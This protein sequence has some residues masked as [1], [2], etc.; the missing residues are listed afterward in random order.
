MVILLRALILF[1]AVWLKAEIF[2]SLVT[3]RN[4]HWPWLFSKA[5]NPPTL[6]PNTAPRTTAVHS[7]IIPISV[8]DV[9]ASATTHT[10]VET[11]WH[12]TPIVAAERRNASLKIDEKECDFTRL[13]ESAAEL[14]PP[15]N[16]SEGIHLEQWESVVHQLYELDRLSRRNR[17]IIM[18]RYRERGYW[19]LR[20]ELDDLILKPMRFA[21]STLHRLQDRL[22]VINVDGV[23]S[24]GWDDR[25]RLS[26]D[27][28]DAVRADINRYLKNNQ[29]TRVM[30][31]WARYAEELRS[32]NCP[33]RNCMQVGEE[34]IDNFAY[35]IIH[36]LLRSVRR[37]RSEL[38]P[39]WIDSLELNDY[40]AW[41]YERVISELK[42]MATRLG[43]EWYMKRILNYF[44]LILGVI[45]SPIRVVIGFFFDILNNLTGLSFGKVKSAI[46]Q[47][48]FTYEN[49]TQGY[50]QLDPDVKWKLL[51]SITVICFLLTLVNLLIHGVFSHELI[52][53]GTALR[54]R[55]PEDEGEP[56]AVN[57]PPRRRS[58]GEANQQ[59]EVPEFE[60]DG[61]RTRYNRIRRQIRA[62]IF[63]RG[64]RNRR[65]ADTRAVEQDRI[66]AMLDNLRLG[67]PDIS[68]KGA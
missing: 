45:F 42:F 55:P 43:F 48:G 47:H 6:G 26:L 33:K 11:V 10:T 23:K 49:V 68:K 9:T 28:L 35:E 67:I 24:T 62:G 50:Q 38:N 60:S 36:D 61:E 2:N 20:R 13:Y 34:P 59:D 18:R 7:V 65:I 53:M 64:T 19:E 1:V 16:V 21:C 54:V 8:G 4:E 15:F 41:L 31:E 3:F 30:P 22:L 29:V 32:W 58:Q 51:T 66:A 44:L 25:V 52:Q 46:G 57:N 14:P 56:V 40:L 39:N 63:R 17:D 5:C 27:L 37:V 12:R